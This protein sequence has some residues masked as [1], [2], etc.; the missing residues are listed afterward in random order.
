MQLSELNAGL[1]LV[2]TPTAGQ[3]E[4][5]QAAPHAGILFDPAA[6]DAA[7]GTLTG[8]L[9]HPEQ[10]RTVQRAARAAAETTYC[11]E[12]ESPRLLALVANALTT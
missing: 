9:R 6:P 2:A 5:L 11:W 10:L 3:R 7:L 12:R 8:W 1:A 4:V